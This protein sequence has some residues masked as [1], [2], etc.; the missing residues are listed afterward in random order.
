MDMDD[1]YYLP[2]PPVFALYQ[3]ENYSY[4]IFVDLLV[5][6][7]N[8]NSHNTYSHIIQDLNTRNNSE[9]RFEELHNLC[10]AHDAQACFILGRIYEFGAYNKTE[11]HEQS[12]HFY[13]LSYTF[14]NIYVPALMSFF[15]RY[16]TNEIPLSIAE[17]ENCSAMIESNIPTSF[18]YF[19]GFLRPKSSITA[20]NKLKVLANAVTKIHLFPTAQKLSPAQVQQLSNSTEPKDMYNLGLHYLSIPY[21]SRKEL[22]TAKKLFAKSLKEG[23]KE[24]SIPMA[25]ILLHL[26]KGLIKPLETL[27]SSFI[28]GNNY[29]SYLL[30]SIYLSS[31]NSE[32]Y[33]K[34]RKLLKDAALSGFPP[35]IA[36]VAE[37][38]YYG[39]FGFHRDSGT[40]Y[41]YHLKAVSKGYLPSLLQAS[42]QL[43]GG[44]G[45]SED[46]GESYDLLRRIIYTG[47]WTCFFDK[48]VARGSKHAFLKML[49]LGLIPKVYLEKEAYSEV[50]AELYQTIRQTYDVF[51]LQNKQGFSHFRK[52]LEGD[53]I[54]LIWLI[55]HAPILDTDK[56]LNQLKYHPS[57]AHYLVLPLRIFIIVKVLYLLFFGLLT[58]IERDYFITLLLLRIL[59]IEIILALFVLINLIYLRIDVTISQ[60]RKYK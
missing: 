51:N 13:N 42:I 30:S 26:N 9:Q 32:H 48:Y 29:A 18:Q 20:I 28:N 44:D 8:P 40:S 23:V 53:S 41:Q 45:V 25:D 43:V 52:A 31:Q 17:L 11:N 15:H 57:F 37:L 49:D 35:A 60:K 12:L 14:G 22:K 59:K 3:P 24:S 55:T 38:H 34:G 1:P 6:T 10:D 19:Y 58:Y 5:F 21:P 2:A 39:L 56:Y 46:I 27:L 7:N 50:E 36:Q 4:P 47:P 33:S 16:Y 54:S